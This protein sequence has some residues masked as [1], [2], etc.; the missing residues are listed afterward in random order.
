MY[1]YFL[2]IKQLNQKVFLIIITI[3]STTT[4]ITINNANI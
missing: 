3:T 2:H 1:R 4:N